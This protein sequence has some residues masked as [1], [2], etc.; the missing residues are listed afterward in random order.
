MDT[1]A[2]ISS[3]DALPSQTSL[4]TFNIPV[5]A[6][7]APGPGVSESSGLAS[8]AI[9]VSTNAGP[10]VLFATIP[11]GDAV[12][13]FTGQPGNTYTFY[14][15][16]TDRAGNVQ[17]TRSDPQATVR[18]N[19]PFAA[20][21]GQ[22]PVF[23]RL[24]KKGQPVGKAGLSGF[25]IGFKAP[26]IATTA[27]NPANYQVDALVTRKAGRKVKHI[28]R[29]ISNF[30]VVYNAARDD[31]MITLERPRR[32]PAGGQVAI[33]PGVTNVGGVPVI[34]RPSLRSPR[35]VGASWRRYRLQTGWPPCNRLPHFWIFQR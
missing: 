35:E 6:F 22:Q 31:V 25:T 16:A 11:P 4:T 33:L 28:L 13:T 32:F 29:P 24:N 20:V 2:P 12:A 18:V 15:V 27:I 9:Y 26:L 7:D 23:R 1:T 19:G 8:I 17:P 10:F 3:L 34:L 5:T 21:V 14:S 30:R